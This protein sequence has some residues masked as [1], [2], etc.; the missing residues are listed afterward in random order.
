MLNLFKID[1]NN[2]FLFG[3]QKPQKIITCFSGP[4]C[5]IFPILYCIKDEETIY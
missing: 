2:F 1:D 3:G 4:S 5:P